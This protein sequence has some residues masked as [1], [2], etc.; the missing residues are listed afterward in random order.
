MKTREAS[1]VRI[2]ASKKD[3]I[4]CMHTTCTKLYDGKKYLDIIPS[5][6][7]YDTKANGY[8]PKERLAYHLFR[9]II[10]AYLKFLIRD[11]VEYGLCVTLPV[12]GGLFKMKMVKMK[13]KNSTYSYCA[14]DSHNEVLLMSEFLSYFNGYLY[15]FICMPTNKFREL[16]VESYKN[17]T[18][19]NHDFIKMNNG[20]S[21]IL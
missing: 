7:K 20:K 10:H 5:A 4:L 6:N 2:K 13:N 16:I 1:F 17:G 3:V 18:R 19:Y 8:N 21:E 14:E 15:K 9:K 11:I 12:M